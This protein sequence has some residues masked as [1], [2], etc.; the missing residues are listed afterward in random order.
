MFRRADVN[1]AGRQGAFH[2]AELVFDLGQT[3]VFVDH[4]TGVQRQ[5]RRHD[6]VVPHAFAAL[7]HLVEIDV[8]SYVIR[9]YRFSCLSVHALFFEEFPQA[10]G[11]QSRYSKALRQLFQPSEKLQKGS[12]F[13]FAS[14]LE[15]SAPVNDDFFLEGAGIARLVRNR[16][17]ENSGFVSE[18]LAHAYIAP[19]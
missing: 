8:S 2:L 3:V 13:P 12:L 1:R 17:L 6:L 10:S 18:I 15:F 14:L 4:L 11:L 9:V 19:S 7:F 16:P 5:F